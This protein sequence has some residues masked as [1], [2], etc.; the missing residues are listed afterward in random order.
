MSDRSV[1]RLAWRALRAGLA[2]AL[3][4]DGGRIAARTRV[5]EHWR[6]RELDGRAPR[7]QPRETIHVTRP[8]GRWRQVD[9]LVPFD[10]WRRPWKWAGLGLWASVAGALGFLGWKTGRGPLGGLAHL[11]EF[12][13]ALATSGVGEDRQQGGGFGETGVDTSGSWDAGSRDGGVDDR[14]GWWSD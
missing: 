4:P 2:V 1:P 5:D 11:D 14:R 3:A 8:I 13:D 10:G 6:R 7:L 9:P 12:G